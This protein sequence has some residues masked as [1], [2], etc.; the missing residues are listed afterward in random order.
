M[1]SHSSS[2]RKLRRK[3]RS[4]NRRNRQD[5][6]RR[7]RLEALED[8]R[9]MAADM[10][11]E[12][13]PFDPVDVNNDGTISVRDMM[14]IIQSMQGRPVDEAMFLDT[15]GDQRVSLRDALRVVNEFRR[16]DRDLGVAEDR[17]RSID[18]TGNNLEN[19]EWGAA[20]IDLVRWTTPEY[21]DGVG[22]PA[23]DDR[24]NAREISNALAAQTTSI[25]NDRGLTDM[26]W[27]WGQ[28]IDHDIDLTVGSETEESYVITVPEG[29]PFFD[30]FATGEVVIPLT[31]SD[32]D[33]STGVRE[34]IN[35]ITAFLDG[36][37][38]YGSDTERAHALRTF[39]GGRLLTSDGDLLPFNTAG[40]DN[41]GGPSDSLFLAGDVR[42]NE[43]AA[44]SAMHTVWVREHNRIAERIADTNPRMSDEQIYQRARMVVIAEIQAITFNEFLPALLGEGA[45]DDY[46]GYDADVNP[47]IANVF[48]TAVYRFGHSMLSSELQRLNPDG[49]EVEDGAL[50]LQEAFFNPTTLVE[51]GIDSLLMGASLNVAQEIDNQV[52]DDVRNFLFGPPGAGGFDLAALNI[53]RGRDHGLPDYNQ[54]RAELGLP[55]VESF[56][57]ITSDAELAAKLEALYGDVDSIDIWVGALAE[58]HV[59]GS[60]VGELAQAV[61]V[62]QFQR[63]R[64]GD[65]L[66]YENV[67]SG[68]ELR[69]IDSTTLA[70]VIG[71][72]TDNTDLPRNVFQINAEQP[73][74]DQ[75]REDRLPP[76]GPVDG[77]VNDSPLPNRRPEPPQQDQARRDRRALLDGELPP[78]E[79]IRN[80]VRVANDELFNDAER[81]G[82]LEVV[83]EDLAELL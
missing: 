3:T 67:F 50:P 38:V 5:A 21:A 49:S 23:G 53:Q 44:L 68:R 54:A 71:R 57:E 6:R 63:I 30:P 1:S 37:M 27:L 42:A 20:G 58:D 62:D 18:G 13:N 11:V 73:D 16:R 81:L 65:R 7:L 12:Q 45:I 66:W 47:S 17:I 79:L 2:R 9:L 26:L 34:Q 39:E 29:D 25:E 61:M 10:V 60:S 41:A 48:S 8:R 33:E 59:P 74:R 35:S 22:K 80:D 77:G 76:G 55:A 19:P 32:Y 78:E 46:S 82:P 15:D 28:F 4:Q 43:N 52:V 69:R 24:P 75:P 56:E 31:R 83:V 72:N 14:P 36:S 40:L 64:D 70:D 51:N